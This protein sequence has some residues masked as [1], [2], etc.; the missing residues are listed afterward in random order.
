MVAAT[1]QINERPGIWALAFPSILANLLYAV[2]VMVQ[3]KFVGELGAES[4]AAIGVG[5]R[6]FFALQA[7]M[8]AISA[9]TTALVARAWGAN[10]YAEAGRVTMASLAMAIVFGLVLTVPGILFARPVA[11][12]F[13]LDAD[14]VQLAADNIMWLSVFN[15]AF[16]TNFIIGAALRAAG[17]AWTPL[18]IGAGVNVVNIPLLYALVFGAWGFPAMGVAGAALAAGLAFSVGGVVM[19]VMWFKQLF[20]V[21][22]VSNGWFRRERLMRLVHI[23]YPAGAEMIVFQLGFFAFLM[24]IGNYYG[25]EAFAAYSVGTNLL[26]ICMVVGFGFS[27]AGSTLVG[28]YLGAEDYAGAVA[29]G[30]RSAIYA[31]TF[32]GIIG[33]LIAYFAEELAYFFLGDEPR[34]VELTAQMTVL[35]GL[36]TP[37]LAVE[38]ALG[39][40]LRGAGDTRFPLIATFFGLIAV[41]CT[42]AATFT[43]LQF[44]VVWVYATLIGD[45]LVKAIMLVWRFH[46]GRWKTLVP[47]DYA[48]TA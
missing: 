5:Q 15:V 6:V 21:K 7:V 28:Q 37:L 35:M 23:G 17:D 30:W 22:Y 45:Y 46:S 29:S 12:I 41:R 26:M 40:A 13:G 31:V 39:G 11:S 19:L 43:F 2:V 1:Q 34:T 48:G 24:L 4:I 44:P 10:D 42:L 9:G 36:A 33:W 32:M 18:W 16:A 3:T 25:T 47:T 20:V 38:F 14:T 27:I 8:M